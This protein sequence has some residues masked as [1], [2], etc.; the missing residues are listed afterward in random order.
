MTGC[1]DA[2]TVSTVLTVRKHGNGFNI[3]Y[4]VIHIEN[5]LQCLRKVSA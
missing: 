5:K 1:C 4:L 3:H 2:L